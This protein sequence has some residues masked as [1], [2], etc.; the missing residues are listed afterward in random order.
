MQKQKDKKIPVKTHETMYIRTLKSCVKDKELLRTNRRGLVPLNDDQDKPTFALDELH[1][2]RKRGLSYKA[3]AKKIGID[4]SKEDVLAISRVLE[5]GGSLPSIESISTPYRRSLPSPLWFLWDSELEIIKKSALPSTSV[6]MSQNPHVRILKHLGEDA[7][8]LLH[9]YCLVQ[10]VVHSELRNS[11]EYASGVSPLGELDRWT[12]ALPSSLVDQVLKI[13]KEV[14]D[15]AC[16]MTKE[17]TSGH[18]RCHCGAVK[19]LKFKWKSHPIQYPSFF[20][21]CVKYTSY[22]RTSHDSAKSQA[23]SVWAILSDVGISL[24][25]TDAKHL[26][27]KCSTLLGEIEAANDFVEIDQFNKVY[28]GPSESLPI[29][30][31]EDVISSLRDIL[32]AVD[33][34]IPEEAEKDHHLLN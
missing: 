30:G 7:G 32:V 3:I 29:K 21:G 15:A 34:F 1:R 22:D 16:Q 28:G 23:G 17:H 2:N 10:N 25:P 8:W 31:V 33:S 5:S 26:H 14:T 18:G 9:T 12:N 27:S 24:L 19:S 20:W 6:V 4:T 11:F 13:E